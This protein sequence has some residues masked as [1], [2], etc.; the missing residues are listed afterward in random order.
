MIA[1]MTI[2]DADLGVL[3]AQVLRSQAGEVTDSAVSRVA[4][5]EGGFRGDQ[6]IAQ[7][8]TDRLGGSGTGSRTSSGRSSLRSR[9]EGSSANTASER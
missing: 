6:R 1:R 9:R 8:S 3:T 5:R 4:A 2:H 7:G